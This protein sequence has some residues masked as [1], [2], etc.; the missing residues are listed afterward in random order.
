MVDETLPARCYLLAGTPKVGKS[1]PWPGFAG[2]RPRAATLWDLNTHRSTV[3]CLALE[4]TPEQLQGRL[5]RMFDADWEGKHFY[6]D[7]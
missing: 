2:V 7:F 4:D 1:F 3:L 6:L 5:G